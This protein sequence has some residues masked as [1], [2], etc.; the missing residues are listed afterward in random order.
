[1][2]AAEVLGAGIAAL[3]AAAIYEAGGAEPTWVAV[4][5]A[6]L[7]LLTIGHS[8]LRGTIPA[9]PAAGAVDWTPIDTH[10]TPDSRPSLP[11]PPPHRTTQSPR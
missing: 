5:G 1:M 11:S 6:P 10:P 9:N 7:V 3:P 8:R 2:G 4:G